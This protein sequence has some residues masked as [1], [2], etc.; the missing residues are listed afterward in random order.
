MTGPRMLPTDALGWREAP[1]RLRSGGRLPVRR[2]LRRTVRGGL[3]GLPTAARANSAACPDPKVLLSCA[4]T[5][6]GV[7]LL[8]EE[9]WRT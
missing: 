4:G 6:D 7:Q 1:P 3:A 8:D 5:V 9:W 2:R